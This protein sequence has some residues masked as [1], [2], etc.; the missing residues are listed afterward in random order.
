MAF[1]GLHGDLGIPKRTR[2]L[3]RASRWRRAILIA[4]VGVSIDRDFVH[5]QP[6]N[7]KIRHRRSLGEYEIER[8]R[9]E[10]HRD[11]RSQQ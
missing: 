4:T 3:H 9:A 7:L 2:C 6:D 8:L 11:E 1:P 5:E 10:K